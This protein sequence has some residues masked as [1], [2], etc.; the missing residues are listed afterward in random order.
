MI[1]ILLLPFLTGLLGWLIIWLFVK[2]LFFPSK[3]ITIGTFKWDAGLYVLIDKLPLDKILPTHG[4]Q[5]SSFD[6]VLPFIDKELDDFFKHK[7]SE[8][9]PIV[10][11]FIGDKT[12][13]QLKEVFL[14]EL[15]TLF[16]VVIS[17]LGESAKLNLL[18]N[19]QKKWKPIIEPKLLEATKNIRW[20][21][22]FLGFFWGIL[23][24]L[25]VH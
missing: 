25:M 3:S 5:N 12:V 18:Q 16:P 10:S 9:M 13:T 14:E 6:L 24:L 22:F 7:L 2:S 21:A 17:K 20:A 1:S 11:M 23:I 8:K 19:L 4:N 15:N